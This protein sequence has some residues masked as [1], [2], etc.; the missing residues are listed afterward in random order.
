MSDLVTAVMVT[1]K[2]AERR[3]LAEAAVTAFQA[4]TWPN[5]ELLI[6]DDSGTVWPAMPNVRQ[7]DVS[8]LTGPATLGALRNIGLDQAAGDWLIQW[9]DDDW[10]HPRRIEYMMAG[11]QADH[12]V[13]L[14][15]QIRYSFVND[16]AFFLHY[17]LS[18]AGI[19]GSVLH[20]RTTGRYQLIGKHEDSRFLNNNFGTRRVLLDN[21]QPATDGPNIYLRFHHGSNTWDMHHIMGRYA[22]PSHSGLWRLSSN[23]AQYLR[24]VLSEHYGR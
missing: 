21:A 15:H 11:A 13:L 24:T 19:P 2:H 22:A 1:G 3:W 7:A 20:P 16:S 4:Q 14:T 6:V 8:S 5:K 9:D 17:P 10:Y 12:A 23:Q 18:Y